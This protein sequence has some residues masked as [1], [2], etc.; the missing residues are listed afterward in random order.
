MSADPRSR[1]Y[2]LR[3]KALERLTE[4][5]RQERRFWHSHLAR[6]QVSSRAVREMIDELC[7][8]AEVGE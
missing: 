1:N 4:R 8:L 3:K 6:E 2:R 5:L 7:E